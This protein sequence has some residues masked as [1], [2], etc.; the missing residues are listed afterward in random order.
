MLAVRCLLLS[1]FCP[2]PLVLSNPSGSLLAFNA[3]QPSIQPGTHLLGGFVDHLVDEWVVRLL[4]VE[5]GIEHFCA[6]ISNKIL[7][8]RFTK[9]EEFL[10]HRTALD[11]KKNQWRKVKQLSEEL[12]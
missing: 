1:H 12:G 11:N 8:K 4:P 6:L 7:G 2:N 9:V 3:D 5:I 10:I